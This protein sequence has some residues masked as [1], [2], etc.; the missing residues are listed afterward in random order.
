MNSNHCL[1]HEEELFDATV[2]EMQERLADI[3]EE[4]QPIHLEANKFR[5]HLWFDHISTN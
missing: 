5:G 3:Q 2:E 4:A 1:D